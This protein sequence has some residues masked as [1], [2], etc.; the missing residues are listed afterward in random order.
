[1]L[2]KVYSEI[3]QLINRL[4][5]VEGVVGIILFGSYSKGDFDEGS[6]VDLLIV[7]NDKKPWPRIKN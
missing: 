6:D 1:M 3:E 2:L 7:F 4:E 5:E